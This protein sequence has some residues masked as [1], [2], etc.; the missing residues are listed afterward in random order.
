MATGEKVEGPGPQGARLMFLST[1]VD[2]EGVF[3]VWG[4]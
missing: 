1:R 3:Y 4:E 2:G